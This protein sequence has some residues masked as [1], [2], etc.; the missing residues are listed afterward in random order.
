MKVF[1]I[2]NSLGTGG[3]ESILYSLI[4]ND[5]KGYHVIFLISEKGSEYQS[6][7]KLKN[8]KILNL[9]SLTF[10]KRL[11]LL[12]K[13]IKNNK[14]IKNQLTFNSWMYKSHIFLFLIKIFINFQLIVNVRHC[15]ITNQHS[16]K[17]KIPIYITL[18]F[19]KLF[20]NRIIYNSFFSKKNH[21]KIGFP[22]NKG[23]VIQ[24]GFQKIDK[25]KK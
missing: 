24:N 20:A 13:F 11:L 10:L 14:G 22:K 7:F 3:S 9:S 6:F 8:C 2:I 17:N 5:L 18:F 25:K 15:G 21:E 4:K 16:I 19:S 1:H 12:F 23:I